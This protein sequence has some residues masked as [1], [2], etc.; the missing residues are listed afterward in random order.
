M[1]QVQLLWLQVIKKKG[2]MMEKIQRSIRVRKD[3]LDLASKEAER[4]NRSL[5]NMIE[6]VLADRYKNQKKGKKS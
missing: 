5:N 4:Q 2:G 3:L 6:Q 1:I